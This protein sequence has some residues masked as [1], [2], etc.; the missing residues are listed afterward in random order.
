MSIVSDLL[1]TLDTARA[2]LD[3]VG[4]R[5][6]TV[7]LRVVTWEGS[8]PGQGASSYVDTPITVAGGRRP[9][10]VSV[11]DEDAVAGGLLTT[12]TYEVRNITPA[13]D[14]GGFAAHTLDPATKTNPTQV[15][16][17]LQGPGMPDAGMMCKKVGDKFD[18]VFGYTVV[19]ETLGKSVDP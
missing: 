3:D 7:T 4:L 14:G 11:S 2:L 10:V 18:R 19:I 15:F 6:Y 9:K 1:G 17:I 12:T 16:Y 8:R 13:Y 5:P